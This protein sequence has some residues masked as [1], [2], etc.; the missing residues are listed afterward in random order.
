MAV[1]PLRAH[2][3]QPKKRVLSSAALRQKLLADLRKQSQ[4]AFRTGCWHE[5][6]DLQMLVYLARCAGPRAKSVNFRGVHFPLFFGIITRQVRCPDT[7]VP[8]VGVV[9]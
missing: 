6:E 2:Q 9:C 1:I 5:S 3:A 7:G 8:L 4:A